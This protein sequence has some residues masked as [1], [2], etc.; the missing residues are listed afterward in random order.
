M[1]DKK[2]FYTIVRKC[3][4]YPDYLNMDLSDEEECFCFSA[5]SE[6]NR[7]LKLIFENGEWMQ[8]EKYG[9]VRHYVEKRAVKNTMYI[10]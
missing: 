6:A 9:K 7:C 2:Y 8:D 1:A 5:E 3:Y 4:G 10:Y